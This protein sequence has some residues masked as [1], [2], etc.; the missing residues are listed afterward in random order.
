MRWSLRLSP[1][2]LAAAAVTAATAALVATAAAQAVAPAEALRRTAAAAEAMKK[3]LELRALACAQFAQSLNF[4]AAQ[5]AVLLRLAD[6]QR[7]E[8]NVDRAAALVDKATGSSRVS[9]RKA[10]KKRLDEPR[11]AAL[12]RVAEERWTAACDQFAQSLRGEV[13]LESAEQAVTCQLARGELSE[14]RALLST[15]VPTL[16]TLP[17]KLA[18]RQRPIVSALSS[19]VDR[20]Q[21][22]L[23]LVARAGSS[24]TFSVDGRP[25]ASGQVL[26]LDPGEHTVVARSP[27][28]SRSFT[29][30][31]QLSEKRV[32]SLTDELARRASAELT[33]GGELLGLAC[34]EYERVAN[35]PRAG[36]QALD[37][38]A[39]CKRLRGDH[40]SADALWTSSD[41]LRASGVA[42]LS[43]GELDAT[44]QAADENLR[45]AC[46]RFRAGFELEGDA[47]TALSLDA[48]L[49]HEG[50]L[51]PAKEHL[52]QLLR[53]PGALATPRDPRARTLAQLARMLLADIDR[54]QPKLRVE[55]ARGFQ[56]EI[57]LNRLPIAPNTNVVVEPGHYIVLQIPK[58][59]PRVVHELVIGER[60]RVVLKH[61]LRCNALGKACVD[62]EQQRKATNNLNA[63]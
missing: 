17:P 2:R 30:T 23:T 62:P 54:M 34:K 4:N 21:P 33:A 50:K 42:A 6:C 7:L 35:S 51:R 47:T 49:I 56:G 15:V 46:A 32:L 43:H 39:T 9:L 12:A 31:L 53:P 52:E 36:A 29:I 20:L 18:K 59:G 26:P 3:G 28:T 5:R 37:R 13:S 45:Q 63:L 16:A 24:D 60:E 19:E 1:R 44:L 38:L 58:Q 8:G 61:N 27:E 57:T 25:A 10:D 55:P 48:C 14:A 22:Y 11:A 41:A 40:P